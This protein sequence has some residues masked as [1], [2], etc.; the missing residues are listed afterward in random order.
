MPDHPAR[1]ERPR[2]VVRGQHVTEDKVARSKELRRESTPAE[3]LLCA[4]VRANQVDGL[5]FRRQ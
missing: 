1:E 5:R 3:R 4:H 2:F